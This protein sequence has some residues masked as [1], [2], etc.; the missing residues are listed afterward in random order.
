VEDVHECQIAPKLPDAG[1]TLRHSRSV[2]CC[3][4]E[5]EKTTT[6][7]TA[8]GNGG[9]EVSESPST[10]SSSG[11]SPRVVATGHHPVKP[12]ALVTFPG[13]TSMVDDAWSHEDDEISVQVGTTF[14]NLYIILIYLIFLGRIDL[15]NNVYFDLTVVV[16]PAAFTKTLL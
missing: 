8:N 11:R 9:R 1:V 10:A 3:L 15:K 7:A 16:I 2:E 13:M 12:S 5:S 14:C 4:A 6:V